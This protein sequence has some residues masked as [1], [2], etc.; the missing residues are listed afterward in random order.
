MRASNIEIE[1][2]R[3]ELRERERE[4]GQAQHRA[5]LDFLIIFNGAVIKAFGSNSSP[6]NYNTEYIC[7]WQYTISVH[8]IRY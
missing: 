6:M 7:V 8:I 5:D 2:C 4:S 1:Q 3:A